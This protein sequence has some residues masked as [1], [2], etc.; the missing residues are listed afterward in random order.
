MRVLLIGGSGFI[1]RYLIG[2]LARGG[3][4]VGVLGRSHRPEGAAHLIAGDRKRLGEHRAA[5]AAFAPE[6]VVD[7]IASSA[8]QARA[9]VEVAGGARRLVVLSSQDV[10]RACAVLHRLEPGPLQP[11]PLTEDAAL[12]TVAGTYPPAQLAALQQVSGWLD[13]EYDK[14]GVERVMREAGATVL[15]LPMVYGPGDPLRRLRPIVK[16]IADGRRAIVLPASVAAWRGSRG[17]VEDVAHAIALAVTRDAAAARTYN[18]AERDAPSELDWARYVAA[19]MQWDGEL[20]VLPDEQ[21]PAHLRLPGNAAQ[22]W[23]VDATRIRAE[24]G[25]TEAID[26]DEALRRT[27]AWERA[28]PEAGFSPHRFDYAAEDAALASR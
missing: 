25:Y 27:I 11:L 12:R 10:Y 19:Q 7:L 20:V 2:E 22:H 3:H 5:I 14:L 1:G 13:A 4:E 6:V 16:R 8:A 17:H 21:A 26:R 9:L 15:R 23:V 18:V 24:L 28:A